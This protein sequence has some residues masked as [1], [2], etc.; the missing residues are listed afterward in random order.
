MKASEFR[1][2]GGVR[3]KLK[4]SDFDAVFVVTSYTIAGNG[5][6]FTGG[7]TPVAVNGATWGSSNAVITQCK[8]GS[9]VY[10]DDIKAKGPDGRTRALPPIAF[11]L[12]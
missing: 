8:P 5:A 3:A 10:I 1:V 2:M 12:Q 4:D 11:Q 7:Y 6:G 9:T